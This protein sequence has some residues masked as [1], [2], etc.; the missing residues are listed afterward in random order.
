[1]SR[2]E[3]VALYR[4]ADV[5]LVTPLR[6]GMN[7]VAKE[8]VA[9]RTDE[10]G[11]LVLCEFAGAAS[12]L[13]EAILVNPFDVDATAD[14]FHRAL[15]MSEEESRRRMRAMRRRVFAFNTTLWVER[16]VRALEAIEHGREL[17][18][19]LPTTADVLRR[20]QRELRAAAYLVVLLDYDGTL[21][22]LART[23]E[24]AIPDPEAH[25][26][27]AA[28]CRRPDTEV[29]V[30]SGRSAEDLDRWLGSLPVGLHAEHGFA[31]GFPAHNVGSRVSASAGLA[32]P[33][34]DDPSRSSRNGPPVPWSR[35]RPRA[36][37]GTIARPTPSSP[38]C[39]RA[40]YVSICSSYC[41][42]S[43][44]KYSP[45]TMIEV[46]PQGFHKGRI[47]EHVR[48]R[49]PADATILAMGDDTTDEDMFAALRDDAVAIHVGP[50]ASRACL[51][52]ANV[53]AVRGFLW[54]L[55]TRD[56]EAKDIPATE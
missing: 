38:T 14:A 17:I 34:H 47:V 18:E 36:R 25:Q 33:G 15:T 54:G 30:V 16:F 53:S 8:F 40:S 56:D 35:K 28:L 29:H 2:D 10:D 1:M 7:L 21:V 44:S 26:L 24:L 4:A 51:R 45:A 43:R 22:P 5:M 42:T 13:A 48:E 11:V 52:V 20:A 19:Q 39:R 23:P 12:E 41:R 31:R 27:L 49:A 46:R 50:G 37:P 3:L 55:L 9:S 6:D 32:R